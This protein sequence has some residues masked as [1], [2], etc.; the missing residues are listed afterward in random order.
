MDQ[1]E[2]AELEVVAAIFRTYPNAFVW[3]GGSVMRL[4]HRSPR[5]SYDID[6][7]PRD[8]TPP[9]GELLASVRAALP[10]PYR[11]AG[12]PETRDGFVRI[13]IDGRS[14]D[15]GFTVDLTGIAG[16]IRST[17]SILVPS[18]TGTVAVRIPAS[19]VLLL[20]KLRALL[21]RRFPKPG[22]LFDV[23]FLLERGILLEQPDRLSLADE[24]RA[25]G[26]DDGGVDE[27]LRS[28]RGTAWVR[29]LERSG[30]TGLDE[31][32]AKSLLARVRAYIAEA[33]G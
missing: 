13:R 27:I 18:L 15:P 32:S 10:E 1:I 26:L 23:W 11:V 12:P 7:A 29:A 21:F 33:I 25:A 31:E 16:S 28:F 6:L 14:G 4:I 30:V 20:Q 19:S 2:R 5:A 17:A 22:D 9:A 3:V 8:E 24:A